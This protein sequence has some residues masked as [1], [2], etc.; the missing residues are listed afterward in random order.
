MCRA[1]KQGSSQARSRTRGAGSKNSSAGEAGTHVAE[2]TDREQQQYTGRR[3]MEWP[4]QPNT[5]TGGVFLEITE[6]SVFVHEHASVCWLYR[7]LQRLRNCQARQAAWVWPALTCAGGRCYST[8][9]LVLRGKWS[10]IS[11]LFHLCRLSSS[12][13][14]TTIQHYRG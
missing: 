5:T 10:D 13:P 6:V 11:L 1:T 3:G 2:R 4:H 9:S 8:D 7:L 14:E 12:F